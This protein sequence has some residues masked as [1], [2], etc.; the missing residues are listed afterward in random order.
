MNNNPKILRTVI[1][2][3]IFTSFVIRIQSLF[4]WNEPIKI[5]QKNNDFVK[6]Y[7]AMRFNSRTDLSC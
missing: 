2:I 3:A 5:I 6:F 4:H 1:I 7:C